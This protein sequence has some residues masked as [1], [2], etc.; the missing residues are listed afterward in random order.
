MT[1]ENASMSS[2]QHCNI[3]DESTA[4]LQSQLQK[5]NFRVFYIYET[6]LP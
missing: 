6:F 1:I 3:P 4:M 5:M 2:I